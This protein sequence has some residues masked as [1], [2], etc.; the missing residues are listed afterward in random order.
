MVSA[1]V[2]LVPRASAGQIRG[3]RVKLLEL[4]RHH[5]LSD[6]RLASGAAPATL[7]VHVD[8]DPTYKPVLRF[9]ADATDV[10][11]A[12]PHTVTDDTPAARA[13]RSAQPL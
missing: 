6:V 2:D 4:A 8:E 5:G 9:L 11:G 7:V 3:A 12:E 1:D 13:L 10:L